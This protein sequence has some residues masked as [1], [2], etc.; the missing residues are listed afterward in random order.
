MGVGIVR[1]KCMSQDP[2]STVPSAADFEKLGVFYLGRERLAGNQETG[3]EL[4][5]YDSKDLVTHGVVLGMTGS[6]KTGLCMAILEEAAMDGIP[7]III[8]PKGDIANLL[9]TFPDLGAGDFR[10]WIN[11]DDARRKGVAPDDFAAGQA[12]LWKSGLAKWGQDGARI[13]QMRENV[14]MAIYTPGSSTGLPVSI[15]S[16]MECPPPEVMDDT[17]VLA[18]RIESTVSSLLALL[19]I[20]ADPMQSR[21]HLFLS[22]VFQRAWADGK[23]LELAG[24]I[25]ALQQP[26]FTQ[27]GVMPLDGFFPEKDR[28]ALAM[29]LNGLLAAPGFESWLQ[30]EPLDVS[31]MLYSASGKPRVAIFSIAHLGDDQRMFFVSLLLNQM[32]GWMRTQGGTTSLRAMLYMDEIFGFLPPTANPPSKKPMMTLLKQARAFGLGVLLA[33]QN[34]VDLDYKAL[35]NIGTWFLGR[36]QTERDKA[37]VLDGLEGAA[38][39][40]GAGFDRAGMEKLLSS[41]DNRIFL[42]NNVHEDGPRAFEVRWCMSYL[43]GPLTRGQIKSLMDPRRADA[44]AVK[45]PARP[46]AAASTTGD[47]TLV[48]PKVEARVDEYFLPMPDGAEATACVYVPKVLRAGRVVIEDAKLGVDM[49]DESCVL[50]PIDAKKGSADWGAVDDFDDEVA[51][52]SR[53]PEAGVGFQSLPKELGEAGFYAAVKKDFADVLARDS[54]LDLWRSPSLGIVSQPGE[55][56][57]DFRIRL[58]QK[59]RE[60]RDERVGLL[61]EDYAKRLAREQDDVLR[62]E[63]ALERE[64]QQASSSRWSAVAGVGASLLGALFGGKKKLTSTNIRRVATAGNAINRSLGQSSDVDRAAAKLA[65]ERDEV[66]ALEAELATRIATIESTLDPLTET[67]EKVTIKPLKKNITVTAVGLAWV[68][69]VVSAG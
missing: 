2:N 14:D 19:G 30:G 55:D 4:L 18:D 28:N 56:E 17:E 3:S 32:V 40:Q 44:P 58:V 9:L 16:S 11:E 41:L 68:P 37:R 66:A 35:S 5:L 63:A 54:G 21:E 60:A 52:L 13:R 50:A 29:R 62:A 34:P 45:S 20:Q 12:E 64:K 53:K 46:A 49:I 61:R 33:T 67:L 65:V 39:D 27:V 38:G 36:L 23:D 24:L 31:R 47:N 10:P 6:G 51:A 26:P 22:A 1:Y 25:Q 8:D 43:R 15:L 42:M 48:K 69:T 7:A 59:A 57:R